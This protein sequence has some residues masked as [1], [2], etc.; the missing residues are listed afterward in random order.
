MDPNFPGRPACI[1]Y[2]YITVI[3]YNYLSLET[4]RHRTPSDAEYLIL[5]SRDVLLYGPYAEVF[6]NVFVRVFRQG[7]KY[8]K[9]ALLRANCKEC[10]IAEFTGHYERGA[11]SRTHTH[12]RD[13]IF[14]INI[15]VIAI[16]YLRLIF[17]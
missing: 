9:K 12:T 16:A 11:L 2:L 4:A 5:T 3:Y 6:T 10:I 8:L 7:T 14:D 15:N 17:G 13:V 1:E